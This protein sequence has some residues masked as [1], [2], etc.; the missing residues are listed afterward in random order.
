MSI[1]PTSCTEPVTVPVLVSMP[2]S[3]LFQMLDRP[4]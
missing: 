2:L 3:W 4:K 1:G